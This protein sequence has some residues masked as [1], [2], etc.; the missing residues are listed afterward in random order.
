MFRGEDKGPHRDAL[1]MGTSLVLEV[2]GAVSSPV[3]GVAVAAAAIDDGSAA[4]FL[5][6]LRVHFGTA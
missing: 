5:D 4:R 1:L 2:Q 6:D 3:E